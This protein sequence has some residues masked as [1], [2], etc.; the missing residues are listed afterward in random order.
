MLDSFHVT[1]ENEGVF[2]CTRV[3]D[4]QPSP[5]ILVPFSQNDPR[6]RDKIY[7]YTLTFGKAGCLVC[8]VT[9]AISTVYAELI[10]PTEVAAN[11]KH[12]GAFIG[13]M[14]S[15]P[16]R[17]ADAYPRMVWDGVVHWRDKPADMAFLRSEL[18][19]ADYAI[20][21]VK[22]N[23]L[24]ADPQTGNQHFVMVESLIGD[25]AAIIDPWD[26][27]RKLLS[28]SRFSLPG[29]NAARTITGLRLVRPK[30]G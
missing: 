17:I 23:P 25:D 8:C 27:E 3:E 14:L 1:L 5:S 21:E 16:S 20:A 10:L 18:A 7:A 24:G 11:L 9:M 15:R 4:V 30:A 12:A 6:W 19:L 22:W 13:D 26:G 2:L 29:W 28:E